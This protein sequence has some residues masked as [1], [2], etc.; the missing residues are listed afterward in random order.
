MRIEATTCIWCSN[1]SQLGWSSGRRL[2][3]ELS[4]AVKSRGFCVNRRRDAL[5]CPLERLVRRR[6][7]QFKCQLWWHSTHPSL[8]IIPYFRPVCSICSGSNRR[9]GV[10]G[11]TRVSRK[12]CSRPG[13]DIVHTTFI[14]VCSVSKPCQT[15]RGMYNA[16]PASILVRLSPTIPKPAPE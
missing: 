7:L 9:N 4:G 10:S 5:L 13:G 15:P 6:L 14:S 1:V 11:G 8:L 16:S 12:N 3:F 2:T